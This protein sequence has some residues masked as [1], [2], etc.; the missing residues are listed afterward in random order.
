MKLW[1]GP[2]GT[3]GDLGRLYSRR[4]ATCDILDKPDGAV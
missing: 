4:S 3:A 1:K 2:L